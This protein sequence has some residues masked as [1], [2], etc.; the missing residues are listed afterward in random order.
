MRGISNIGLLE[1]D[2]YTRVDGEKHKR[3]LAK[4][5]LQGEYVW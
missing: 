1:E 2:C 4:D 5:E 3:S